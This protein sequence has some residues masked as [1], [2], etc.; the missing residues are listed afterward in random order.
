[1]GLT[2]RYKFTEITLLIEVVVFY[3]IFIMFVFKN[4]SFDVN[5]LSTLSLVSH[6]E[7]DKNM[8]LV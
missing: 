8:I 6:R 7:Y 5:T 3:Y 4:V 1:M 2:R